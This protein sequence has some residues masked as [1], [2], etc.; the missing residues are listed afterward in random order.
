MGFLFKKS[1]VVKKIAKNRAASFFFRNKATR[2]HQVLDP[3][4][5]SGMML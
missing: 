2:F 3:V 4:R 1:V 5:D